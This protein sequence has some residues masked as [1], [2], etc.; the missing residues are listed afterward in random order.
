MRLA[1]DSAKAVRIT[2]RFADALDRAD[3]DQAAELV[4]D[5]C[6][7]V[8]R[9]Q[10]ICGPAAIMASYAQNDTWATKNLDRIEYES[11]VA[12]VDDTV[13]AAAVI[14]FVDRVFHQGKSHTFTCRQRITLGPCGRIGRIEHEDAEGAREAL[15]AFYVSCGLRRNE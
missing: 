12:P 4:R 11:S 15:E 10:T 2:E 6:E 3:F 9:G 5:D 1:S 14:T 8:I 13:R 7:Y